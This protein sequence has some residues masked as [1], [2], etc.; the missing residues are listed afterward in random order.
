MAMNFIVGQTKRPKH[1]EDNGQVV[2]EHYTRVSGE[3]PDKYELTETTTAIYI[4]A[5]VLLETM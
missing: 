4:E 5:P 3:G 1:V 2:F